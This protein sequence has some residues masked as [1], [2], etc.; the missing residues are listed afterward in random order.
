[1]AMV[2][3]CSDVRVTEHLTEGPDHRGHRCHRLWCL[4]WHLRC[5]LAEST[6][7]RNSDACNLVGPGRQIFFQKWRFLMGQSSINGGFSVAIFDNIWLPDYIQILDIKGRM[8]S[9]FNDF[10]LKSHED[11]FCCLKQCG[12][13]QHHLF[14][15]GFD[16]LRINDGL[17]HP[18]SFLLCQATF[19]A[20][21]SW[22]S[23]P[24]W[25]AQVAPSP[26]F[27]VKLRQNV[28]PASP[29]FLVMCL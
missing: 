23:G 27:S 26:C 21:F 11:R 10:F 4:L 9:P 5:T 6:R 14:W 16:P 15:S 17:I 24:I 18:G 2:F 13:S 1:M 22:G 20:T 12:L 7:S 8:L 3:S 29:R 19:L 28:F 25:M